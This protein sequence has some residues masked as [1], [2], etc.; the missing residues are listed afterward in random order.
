ML[1][2]AKQTTLV[3]NVAN[4]IEQTIL[5]QI[6]QP[7]QRLPPPQELMEQSGISRGS[8]RE[9]L[10]ILEQKGLIEIRPGA[11]GG[12]FVK[13]ASATSVSE[14]LDLL[15]RHR[16]ISLEDLTEFRV[17][18]EAGLIQLVID[19]ATDEDLKVLKKHIELMRVHTEKGASGWEDF[20]T[21]SISLRKSL[22]QM[23]RNS[24]YEA[25]LIPLYENIMAYIQRYLPAEN[26]QIET[27]FK[28]FT[29]II[30]AIEKRDTD[31]ATSLT[32][33]HTQ[34]YAKLYI[35]GRDKHEE[36]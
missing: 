1:K 19:R 22:A 30:D 9:A 15:I 20:L 5:D 6:Y 32:V 23:A 3:M 16:K 33:A 27:A 28:D 35:V 18:V 36:N 4:Q 34:R 10:R 11:K 12:A 7:G 8:I 13:E 17:V 29:D 2:K 31:K 25:V 21:V 14:S 24:M 26:A